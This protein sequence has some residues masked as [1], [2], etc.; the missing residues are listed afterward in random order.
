MEVTRTS[1]Y[2]T[3]HVLKHVLKVV[4]R[5]SPRCPDNHDMIIICTI[6]TDSSIKAAHGCKKSSPAYQLNS[7]NFDFK[8]ISV[9]SPWDHLNDVLY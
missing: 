9:R 4:L 6:W 8:K 7:L 5:G 3:L 2:C 1:Q